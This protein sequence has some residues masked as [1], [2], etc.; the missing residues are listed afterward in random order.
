LGSG[1]HRPLTHVEIDLLRKVAAG[2]DVAAPHPPRQRASH[3][4]ARA[5]RP[6]APSSQP[7]PGKPMPGRTM[8]GRPMPGSTM[9]GRPMH[10]K[11]VPGRSPSIKSRPGP[12]EVRPKPILGQPATANARPVRMPGPSTRTE[13]ADQSGKRPPSPQRAQTAP[14]RRIIGLGAQVA[15]G[16]GRSLAGRPARRRPASARRPPRKALGV[17]RPG[18]AGDEA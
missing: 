9:P 5:H 8:R 10:D 6:P 1:E 17:R 15:Q 18:D 4:P 16:A 7:M 12:P 14:R 11:A 3:P 13:A 2:I